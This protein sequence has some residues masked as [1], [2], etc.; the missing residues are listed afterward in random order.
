LRFTARRG[1]HEAGADPYFLSDPA[2]WGRASRIFVKAVSEVIPS[3]RF[4]IVAGNDCLPSDK[5]ITARI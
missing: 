3:W 1:R 4:R 5:R 2:Q